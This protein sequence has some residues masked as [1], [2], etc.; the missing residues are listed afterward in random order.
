MLQEIQGPGISARGASFAGLSMYVAA[1]PRPGLRVERHLRRPGHHRH[2]RR[3]AVRPGRPHPPRTPPTTATAAPARPWRSSSAPTPGSPPSPTRT[4]AGS[5]R[6]QVCRTK[7]GTGHPPRHR[8]RQAGR[9]H[10]PALH[11]PAR[12]RLDHRLP[13]AQR[14]GL[15]AGRRRPSRRPPQHISYTFNWFYAD[16]AR[17]RV[18]QQRRQPGPRPRR[19]PD[20]ARSWPRPRVRVAGLRPGDEHRRLHPARRSTRSPSTRT[21]TSPGTT[22]RPRTTTRPAAA[23]ARCTAA[24]CSTTGSSSW[25][26]AGGVT[27]ASLTQ[28]MAEA[29]AHRPARRGRAARAAARCSTARR[30]PTRRPRTAVQQ[31]GGLAHGGRPAQ[32]DRGR[33]AS[34][35]PRR[36]DPHHGRLVAAAGRRPSSSRASA[37]TSTTR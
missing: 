7:Y 22:S 19:R 12:G 5:Y 27:R 32:G 26:T 13:D 15:R 37:A 21:T 1:R 4:A 28:A 10:R 24:T 9:L 33:L 18:L 34:L 36:R 11:L 31:A 30:S 14:P 16:S 25:S 8:R 3:R 29:A 2:L 20:A 23:T 17:H 6:M 35:R